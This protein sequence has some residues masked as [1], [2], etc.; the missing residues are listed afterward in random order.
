MSFSVLIEETEG[1]FEATVLGAPNLRVRGST[2]S[3]AIASMEAELRERVRKGE[4]VS[5]R[6]EPDRGWG[7]D[8]KSQAGKY[9]DDPTLD[10]IVR[11]AYEARDRE[12]DALFAK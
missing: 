10:E 7:R 4:L 9:K 1:E 11:E 2:R 3:A 12:R 6:L 8:I 5:I